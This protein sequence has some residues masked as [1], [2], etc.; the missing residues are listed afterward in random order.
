MTDTVK[1]FSGVGVNGCGGLGILKCSLPT[2]PYSLPAVS[3]I[4]TM[5]FPYVCNP[6]TFQKISTSQSIFH[7]LNPVLLARSHSI[8]C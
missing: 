3:N 7:S 5:T 4:L 8:F 2:A 1:Y 6:H